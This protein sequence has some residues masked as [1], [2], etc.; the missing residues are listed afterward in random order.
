MTITLKTIFNGLTLKPNIIGKIQ[1]T[2][3]IFNYCS[4][5]TDGGAIFIDQIS[6]TLIL[7]LSSFYKCN[8]E[9][10]G[11]GLTVKNSNFS[12]IRSNC[13]ELCTGKFGQSFCFRIGSWNVGSIYFNL[14]I[15]NVNSISTQ[16]S[17]ILSQQF[18]YIQQN[19]ISNS[20]TSIEYSGLAIGNIKNFEIGKFCQII[21]CTGTA[22]LSFYF[23][24]INNTQKISNFN[25]INCNSN[26]GWIEI[27]NKEGYPLIENSYFNN[28]NIGSLYC[29]YN[30][31][32]GFINFLNC[33]FSINYNEFYH[34]N[35]NN[36]N[37][38]NNYNTLFITF[39]NSNECWEGN[40]HLDNYTN[41]QNIYSF[42]IILIFYNIFN[43]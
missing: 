30:N 3:T 9:E 24:N 17:F 11:G 18:I 13:F 32:K 35:L 26:N 42:K 6:L 41:L 2:N 15:E 4:S 23:F 21:N 12:F 14:T 43:L 25:F 19:N 10:Y 36:S 27:R 33:K 38:F 7:I 8:S 37:I 31:N 16:S 29:Y 5:L 28:I 22:F 40:Y 34:L 39:F 1:I 20:K